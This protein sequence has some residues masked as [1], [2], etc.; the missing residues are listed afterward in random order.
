MK[1]TVTTYYAAEYLSGKNTTTGEANPTTKLHSIAIIPRAFASEIERD[2]WVDSG[3]CREAMTYDELRG[4]CRGMTM[5]R[6][7]EYLQLDLIGYE[8]E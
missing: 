8:H 3:N 1:I 6:F 7:N 2:L 5:Q 4:L